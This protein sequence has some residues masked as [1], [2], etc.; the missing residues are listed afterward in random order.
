MLAYRMLRKTSNFT[1]RNCIFEIQKLTM[2]NL[3]F[4]ATLFVSILSFAQ[5]KYNP[6]ATPNTYQNTDNPNYWKNK[7]PNKAYWPLVIRFD[8]PLFL[9]RPPASDED[10]F[11]MRWLI[12]INKAL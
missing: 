1:N 5:E 8:M 12:G 9:N 11:Q 3:L 7:M 2:K 10:F 6:L 4:V